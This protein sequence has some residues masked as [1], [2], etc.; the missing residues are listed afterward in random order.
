MNC[1]ALNP[2]VSSNLSTA[3]FM[4]SGGMRTG[5]DCGV[6]MAKLSVSESAVS[7]PDRNTTLPVVFP[8]IFGIA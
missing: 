6:M 7:G 5:G 4:V 1:R 3:V 8:R 2:V